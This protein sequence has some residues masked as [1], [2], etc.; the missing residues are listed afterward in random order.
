MKNLCLYFKYSWFHIKG[1]WSVHSF[2]GDCI[3]IPEGTGSCGYLFHE[4]PCSSFATSI[5][6]KK[7]LLQKW[8]KNNLYTYRRG[9][10]FSANYWSNTF[11]TLQFETFQF[12]NNTETDIWDQVKWKNPGISYIWDSKALC[13]RV[14]GRV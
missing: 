10:W 13:V 4:I 5:I 14:E 3:P 2:N 12:R 7:N 9:K 6:S 1:T 11:L 8:N